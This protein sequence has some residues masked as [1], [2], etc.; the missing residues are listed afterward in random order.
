[1]DTE[2]LPMEYRGQR[3]LTA[4]RAKPTLRLSLL[5]LVV[6]LALLAV[7]TLAHADAVSLRIEAANGPLVPQASVT[8]PSSP[9]A[10][11]GAPDGETCA[12]NSVV[13]AIDTGTNG[14][15]SGTWSAGSGWSVDTINGIDESAATGRRWAILVNDTYLN[16]PPCKRILS[17]AETV[18]IYP[19]CGTSQTA[20]FSKGALE[21]GTALPA[22]AFLDSSY[23]LQ[24]WE[25]TTTFNSGIGAS[26]RLPSIAAL[27]SW[28]G[29]SAYTTNLAT[30]QISGT[31][32]LSFHQA[33]DNPVTL[34]KFGYA[35]DR[36]TTCVSNGA[37]GYC[38]TTSPAPVPFDPS[39]FC[40]TTGNDGYCG[41]P[42]NVPPVSHIDSPQQAHVFPKNAHPNKLKGTVGFDPSQTDH[43]DLRLM[44]QVTITVK[45]VVGKRKVWVTKKVHGKKVRR[46]VTKIK[47]RRVKKTVCYG[48]NATVTDWRTLKKCDATTAKP[49]RADGAEVWSYEF[50]ERLPAGAYTFDALAQDGAG[51]VDSTL[52]VG[53]NRVTFKVL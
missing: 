34:S 22:L 29:G 37:D 50:L 2:A 21:I 39:A 46:R 4:A 18:L 8:L 41:T 23:R 44:R 9:V 17:N 26:Q 43:V 38:G 16:D 36:T 42:D 40:T 33:G 52:E 7:P 24:A 31:A 53:R 13:G 35:P 48:W 47:T 14:D 28:P 1:M 11:G 5:A 12:G 10:P 45:K 32:I 3:R 6:S 20:C 15:W 30:D 19:M 51:N 27:F 25:I 49:F